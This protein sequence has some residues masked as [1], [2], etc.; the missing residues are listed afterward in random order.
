MSIDKK[1]K[2]EYKKR[3]NQRQRSRQ[4]PKLWIKDDNLAYKS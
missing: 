4:I 1:E 2:H 3:A